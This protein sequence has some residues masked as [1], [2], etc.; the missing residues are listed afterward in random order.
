LPFAVAMLIL[1]EGRKAVMVEARG[2]AIDRVRGT[3]R[4]GL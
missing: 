3:A 2:F 1:D 4:R